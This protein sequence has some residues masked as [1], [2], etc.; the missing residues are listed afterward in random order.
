MKRVPGKTRV[1]WTGF[2]I[3]FLLWFGIMVAGQLRTSKDADGSHD[4]T[5]WMLIIPIIFGVCL[6]G[7]CYELSRPKGRAE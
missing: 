3:G 5:L 6:G 4:L 2:W 7:F 1:F